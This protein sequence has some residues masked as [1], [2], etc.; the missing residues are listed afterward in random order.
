MLLPFYYL[1]TA[2][3]WSE[4]SFGRLWFW[5]GESLDLPTPLTC[6]NTHRNSV[7]WTAQTLYTLKPSLKCLWCECKML[8]V[9]MNVEKESNHR[10]INAL[11][12]MPRGILFRRMH[13]QVSVHA[14]MQREHTVNTHTSNYGGVM[15]AGTES[16]AGGREGGGGGG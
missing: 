3:H 2:E 7:T 14:H 15:T 1:E 6:L 13:I 12:G 11:S 10:W 8:L 5:V 9:Q 16:H 4:C